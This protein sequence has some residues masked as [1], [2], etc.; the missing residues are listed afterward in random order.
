[1][2]Q[3]WL[4]GN[5][6]I[7]ETNYFGKDN[8]TSWDR[9]TYPA[10]NNPQETWHIYTIDWTPASI[11][12]SIDSVPVR[13]LYYSDALDGANF[14]QTPM[15]IKIGNWVGG[16]A[17]ESE[18]TVEWAGGYSDLTEAPFT[19]YVNN[20]TIEDYT[21]NGTSYTYGDM[22]GSY[23]SI[24]ISNNATGSNTSYNVGQSVGTNSSSSSNSTTS[25]SNSSSASSVVLSSGAST[26]SGGFVLGLMGLGC[27]YL[28]L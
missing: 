9:A 27:A 23:E 26:Q 14:P 17:D 18:G 4:G 1:M 3:E 19:M 16:A 12:W 21:T 6:T 20:V 2:E 25:S 15:R 10:V 11:T 13:T 8:T 24:I 22:S 5:S 28:Y 7:V